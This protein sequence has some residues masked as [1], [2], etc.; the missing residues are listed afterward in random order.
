M[1]E[2]IIQKVLPSP[3]VLERG[4]LTKGLSTIGVSCVLDECLSPKEIETIFNQG[5]KAFLKEVEKTVKSYLWPNN[6]LEVS[7][8]LLDGK[9]VLHVKGGHWK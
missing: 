1:F 6:R 9:I 4:K 2:K 5:T 8:Q 7:F 3:E